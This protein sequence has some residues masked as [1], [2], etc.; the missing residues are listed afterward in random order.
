MS[1]RPVINIR[2]KNMLMEPP[3]LTSFL[4]ES[5]KQF[6]V[7]KIIVNKHLLNIQFL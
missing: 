5:K 3:V 4:K 1:R 6:A 7:M 2:E